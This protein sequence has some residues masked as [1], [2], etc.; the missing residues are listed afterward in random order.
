M[1]SRIEYHEWITLLERLSIRF[2]LRSVLYLYPFA[3]PIRV[4]SRLAGST[5]QT[6]S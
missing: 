1:T 3:V 5:V 2:N 4:H 6:H